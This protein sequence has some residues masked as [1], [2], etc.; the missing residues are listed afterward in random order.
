MCDDWCG[1]PLLCVPC[2][3]GSSRR[4]DSDE[5]LEA[6]QLGGGEV[7]GKLQEAPSLETGLVVRANNDPVQ[8]NRRAGKPLKIVDVEYTQWSVLSRGE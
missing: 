8:K 2:V 1:Y 3:V 7:R 5:M 6:R 4:G